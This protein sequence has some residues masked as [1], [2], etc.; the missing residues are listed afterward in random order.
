MPLCTLQWL[1]NFELQYTDS[2]PG[3]VQNMGFM[4]QQRRVELVGRTLN[5]AAR[6]GLV[7]E[8]AHDAIL[9]MDRTMSTSLQAR[10]LLLVCLSLVYK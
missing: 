4:Y 6:L 2:F 7:D 9:L 8:Y 1:F 5:F 10:T 3:A